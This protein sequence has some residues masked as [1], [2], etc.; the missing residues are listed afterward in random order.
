[1]EHILISVAGLYIQINFYPTE[2]EFIRKKLRSE[3]KSFYKYFIV[4]N[5]NI[6]PQYFIDLYDDIKLEYHIDG[7]TTSS[8]LFIEC[9]Q[10][11]DHYRIKTSY[12]ISILQ[13]QFVIFNLLDSFLCKNNGFI[14]HTSANIVNNQAFLFLAP[15]GGGKSTIMNLLKCSY[16]PLV[17][18]FAIIK[19]EHDQ[20]FVYPP[21]LIEKYEWINKSN[22]G[23]PI[24]QVI[25]LEKS[26][27]IHLKPIHDFN[28]IFQ[29]LS[30]QI[31]ASRSTYK[32]MMRNILEFINECR[33]YTLKFT[34]DENKLVRLFKAELD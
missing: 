24:R 22:K 30:K 15:S 27:S 9:C 8:K 7:S 19:K 6:K 4:T 23:Y 1:M 16:T 20:Y 12:W 5:Q 33:F 17:D 10:I 29:L 31:W 18:D 21:L 2:R 14:L 11:I 32:L 28:K 34:K 25:F 13:L 26:K 3:I